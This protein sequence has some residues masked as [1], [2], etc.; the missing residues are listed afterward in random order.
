LI[1][2]KMRR[3]GGMTGSETRFGSA[4]Q[5]AHPAFTAPTLPQSAPLLNTLG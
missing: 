3:S 4:T 1:A 2:F 5:L